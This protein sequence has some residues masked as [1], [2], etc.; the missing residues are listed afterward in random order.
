MSGRKKGGNCPMRVTAGNRSCEVH[1]EDPDAACIAGTVFHAARFIPAPIKELLQRRELWNDVLQTLNLAVISY[2]RQHRFAS[3]E[4][5]T[6]WKKEQYKDIVRHTWRILY[7]ELRDLVPEY[8]RRFHEKFV[9]PEKL[10]FVEAPAFGRAYSRERDL[11]R[12]EEAS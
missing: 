4:G 9:G 6:T 8:K 12:V 11:E 3:V 10:R 5:K 1:Y 2:W 7:H